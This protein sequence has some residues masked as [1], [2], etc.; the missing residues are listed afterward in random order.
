[1]ILDDSAAENFRNETRGSG[2]K[3]PPFYLPSIFGYE[4]TWATRVRLVNKNN[5]TPSRQ[6]DIVLN[7]FVCTFYYFNYLDTTDIL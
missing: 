5:G 6:L 1:M 4:I 2:F 7:R 3:Y